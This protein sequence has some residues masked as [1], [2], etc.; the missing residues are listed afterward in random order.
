MQESMMNFV[1][2]AFEDADVLIYMVEIGSRNL[3]TKRFNKIITQNSVLLKQNWF[4]PRTIRATSGFL[5]R[6]SANAEIY[7]IS[8]LQ[9]FNVP[10]FSK[11]HYT[12]PESPAYYPKINWRISQSVFLLMKPFVKKSYW[13]TAKRFVRSWSVTE[14]FFDESFA[15]VL[16]LW[17][18]VKLKRCYWGAALK[19]NWGAWRFRFF[20][21][22]IHIELVKWTKLEKQHE[23]VEA[24]GI[25]NS[26]SEVRGEKW[27]VKWLR[28]FM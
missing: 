15:F 14:E 16:W 23:Y 6:E 7:P 12:L 19:G 21:K 4:E 27:K 20:G 8:A 13:I 18:N 25:I 1:K 5:D 2:S 3:R 22:Q 28:N 9:N 17:W 26:E 10:V 24:F 11:N